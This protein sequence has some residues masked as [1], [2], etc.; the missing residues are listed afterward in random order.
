MRLQPIRT[1]YRSTPMHFQSVLRSTH[2]RISASLLGSVTIG[3]SSPPATY[4]LTRFARAR[5]RSLD[6]TWA[7]ISSARPDEARQPEATRPGG[8]ACRLPEAATKQA[9]GCL[10]LTRYWRGVAFTTGPIEDDGAGM[11]GVCGRLRLNWAAALLRPRHFWRPAEG[12]AGIAG[13]RGGWRHD[14][15]FFGARRLPEQAPRLVLATILLIPGLE[16]TFT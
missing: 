2:L 11:A 14:R 7:G 15:C 3:R 13:R 5:P 10:S 1:E 9:S 8:A 4:R 16:L 6:P 12:L